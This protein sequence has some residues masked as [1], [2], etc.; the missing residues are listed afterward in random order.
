[1]NAS[2]LGDYKCKV[3]NPLGTLE[4]VIKLTKG[5]KPAGPS[6][7]QL[8]RTFNDGF[9]LDIRSVKYSSV[10]DNMNTLGYRVEYIS[11]SEHKFREGNWSYAK[12]KDFWFHTGKC[13]K[14][15][16]HSGLELFIWESLTQANEILHIVSKIKINGTVKLKQI[17]R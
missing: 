9:E 1:M 8:K 3:A 12:R 15:M 2:H 7:F 4:R 13:R 6:L 10:E 14:Y 16:V 11:E 17:I 5:Q